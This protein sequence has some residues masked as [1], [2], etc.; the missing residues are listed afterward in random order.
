MIQYLKDEL[1]IQHLIIIKEIQSLSTNKYYTQKF[2]IF[3]S[4]S[5]VLK[6]QRK[7]FFHLH[8]KN[9][10][11]VLW[12]KMKSLLRTCQRQLLT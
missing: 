11:Q 3:Y 1:I 4:V 2:C 10:Q 8:R 7:H 5:S 6:T 9:Q 12:Y